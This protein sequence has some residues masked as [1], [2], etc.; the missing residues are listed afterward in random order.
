MA[1]DKRRL[2]AA[3]VC[4]RPQGKARAQ[5][6]AVR[7]AIV[8]VASCFALD[9]H[10]ASSARFADPAKVL[11]VSMEGEEAGFDPQAV[12]DVYSQ[13]VTGAIFEALYQ[14]DYYGG[15]RIV[16]RTAVDLPEISADG[17]TWI[18]RL[19]QGIRFG[20]DPAFKDGS[21]ELTAQDYVYAW[22]RLLDPRVRSPNSEILADRLSGARAAINKAQQGG[23]F[24]YDA[25][26]EGLRARDRYTI[27]LT[28]VEPDYTLLP[29]LVGIAT[30]AVA[31]EVVETYGD[32]S[33]RVMEHPV[34]TG[35]LATIR[36]SGGDN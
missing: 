6:V 36:N 18:I 19:K 13:T 31:R 26:L 3:P 35:C 34:G 28:L 10:G 14:Y 24:D 2:A 29:Y 17:R 5:V 33:S 30:A 8:V 11:R 9:I 20:D 15:P 21:R 27:Q 1:T 16:P 12:G 7:I 22:K 32:S 4:V 25:E 23:R